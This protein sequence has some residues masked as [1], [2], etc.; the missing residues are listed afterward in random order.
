MI[1]SV[2]ILGIADSRRSRSK[3]EYSLSRKQPLAGRRAIEGRYSGQCAGFGEDSQGA[4]DAK[5]L[6]SVSMAVAVMEKALYSSYTQ[7]VSILWVSE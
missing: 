4:R 1:A 6:N 3:P 2:P 5:W 7:T